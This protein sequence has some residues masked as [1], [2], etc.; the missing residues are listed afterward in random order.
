MV[1]S[2][3]VGRNDPCP[4]GSGQKFKYCCTAREP[5]TRIIKS[6]VPCNHCGGQTEANLTDNILNLFSAQ[7][8]KI[9]NYFKDQELYFF[10]SCISLSDVIE[11]EKRLIDKTLTKEFVVELY[12]SKLTKGVALR[13]L[14]DATQ[15]H[16][17]FKNRLYIISDAICAHFQQK[18]T[19]S[20]PVM[21]V[22]IEG[23]LR[24]YGELR[25]SETFKSTIPTEVWNARLMF[26]LTDNAQYFNSF[27]S[28]LFEGQQVSSNFN[29]N[30]I[31]HG[32]NVDYASPERSTMLILTLLEIINF[33]WYDTHTPVLI[34]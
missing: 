23:I 1:M 3:N 33:I 8:I 5:R 16:P 18:Y 17:A 6:N 22:Q 9:H 26:S 32:L 13:L 27:I 28:R 30:T 25:Q 21:L 4:C 12:Q 19:L 34:R 24:E 7:F 20:V 2:K 11:L 31:L 10:Q 15:L 14:N 29:R